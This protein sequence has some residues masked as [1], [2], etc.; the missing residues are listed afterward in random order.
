MAT[1]AALRSFLWMPFCFC[2]GLSSE[3][4]FA[5][6]GDTSRKHTGLEHEL[7]Q[8]V[9]PGVAFDTLG[10]GL[11]LIPPYEVFSVTAVK[12]K[13]IHLD[14]LDD[15]SYHNCLGVQYPSLRSI[16][17]HLAANFQ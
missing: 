17:G 11:I 13:D 10:K 4:L 7:L 14:H 16:N 1:R 8:G 5:T 6:G 15:M 3:E 2:C 9:A 12:G